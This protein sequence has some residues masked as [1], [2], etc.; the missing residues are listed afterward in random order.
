MQIK[1]NELIAVNRKASNRLLNVE[2]LTEAE[3]HALHQFFGV[4]AERA[5]AES[6]LSE[7]HS[8]EEAEEIHEDK[9]EDLEK[10][11]Q[12]RKREK[13]QQKKANL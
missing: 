4:L 6:S 1:L 2:D 13:Q 12:E 10:R 8:I 7:S 11:Q 9:Q 5:K 3:L